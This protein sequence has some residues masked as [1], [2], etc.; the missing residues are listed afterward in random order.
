MAALD[1]LRLREAL[2]RARLL[3]VAHREEI[4]TQSMATFRQALRDPSFG[5]LWCER[6]RP[7]QFEM[8][9]LHSEYYAAGVAHWH[10]I[11]LMLFIIDEFHHAAAQSIRPSL[12]HVRPVESWPDRH[13]ERSDGLRSLIGSRAAWPRSS[14]LGRHRPAALVAFTYY[15]ITTDWICGHPMEAGPGYDVSGLSNCSRNDSWQSCGGGA[16]QACR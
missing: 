6:R 8:C 11:T 13:P 2:P 14:A 7:Q 5:E 4:L 10:Q 9:S 12:Q 15:G 16:R 1:Y 3:F